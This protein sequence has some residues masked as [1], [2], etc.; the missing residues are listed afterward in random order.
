LDVYNILLFGPY[1]ASV[2]RAFYRGPE[3]SSGNLGCGE[4]AEQLGSHVK[5][6]YLGSWTRRGL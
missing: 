5:V 2:S 1:S 3:K 4:A 6:S